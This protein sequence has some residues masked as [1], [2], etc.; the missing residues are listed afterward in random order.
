MAIKLPD[1]PEA[2]GV[3]GVSENDITFSAWEQE[4][5]SPLYIQKKY[6]FDSRVANASSTPN[7][8]C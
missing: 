8:D 1:S 7:P 2:Y 6:N 5:F 3:I 4:D